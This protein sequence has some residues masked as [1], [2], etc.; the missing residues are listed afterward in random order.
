MTSDPEH[1]ETPFVAVADDLSPAPGRDVVFS[2]MPDGAV[3]YSTQSEKYF[4]LNKTGAYI[5]T[6]LY[7]QCETVTGICDALSAEFPNAD[8]QQVRSD[9]ERLLARL[10][11][12]KLIE[13]RNA[14]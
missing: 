9:V 2:T 13:P 4:G 3:L 7:P 8:P 6:H 10:I 11:E 12:Q 14:N 5:W 1:A